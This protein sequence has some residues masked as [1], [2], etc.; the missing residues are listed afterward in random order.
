M[1]TAVQIDRVAALR[2]NPFFGSLPEGDLAQLAPLLREI[3]VAEGEFVVREGEVASEVFVIDE[4]EVQVLKRDTHDDQFHQI[5]RL[6]A[7]ETIGEFALVAPGPR[8]AS[9]RALCPTRLYVLD[10]AAVNGARDAHAALRAHLVQAIAQR[11]RETTDVTV[12]ALSLQVAM[13]RFLTFI[14]VLLTLY[15]Y[16]LSGITQIAAVVSSTTLVTLGVLAIIIG[17]ALMMMR[18]LGY[19]LRFYGVTTDNWR[20]AVRES[21]A[22]T[23][24]AC[25]LVVALKWLVLHLGPGGAGKPLFD[26]YASLNLASVAPVAARTTLFIM[27]ALYVLHAPLQEFL[28]RGCLQSPL[29]HFLADAGGR[30]AAIL[31]SNL[32]FSAFHLYISFGFAVLTFVPGLFW[33]WLYARHGTLTGVALSHAMLGVWAV[34]VVGIEGVVR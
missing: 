25:A 7:G 23:V 27:A 26:P 12:R 6:G 1:P 2:A 21:I 8:S 31:A 16:V 5:R 13:G 29:Q 33:G 24:L 28:V 22:L 14:I 18:R 34:F 9:V 30:W 4:G 3:R 17:S 11:L 20:P 10:A 32:I 19:P 15:A